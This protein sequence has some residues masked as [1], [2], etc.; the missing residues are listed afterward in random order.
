M[1]EEGKT[2]R[3]LSRRP[4][5]LSP[6]PSRSRRFLAPQTSSALRLLHLARLPCRRR[7]IPVPGKEVRSDGEGPSELEVSD[8]RWLR[9]DGD[10][11]RGRLRRVHPSSSPYSAS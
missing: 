3:K 9:R 7:D 11:R 10:I 6:S 8:V 1:M 4:S 2:G 5:P